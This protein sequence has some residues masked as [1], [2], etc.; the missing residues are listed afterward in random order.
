M[1]YIS[2]VSK[3]EF[4]DKISQQEVKE[5]VFKHM[6]YKFP[7]PEQ[8]MDIFDNAEIAYRNFCKP[9]DYYSL[10]NTFQQKNKE[11]GDITLEYSIKAINECLEKEN[12]RP[13][14]ITDILFISTTGL[15]TP[16][17]DALIVNKLQMNPNINRFPIWGMGCGG[18]VS[19]ISKANA[20]A[21][22]NPDALVLVVAAEMCSLTFLN[23]D[24]SKSNFV[25]LSLFSDGIAAVVVKGDNHIQNQKVKI[26]DSKSTLFYD[27]LDIM[28]WEFLNTGFKVIFSRDIP[29]FITKHARQEIDP[30]LA[31]HNLQMK[32][33]KNYIFH[34][35]GKKVL[36]AYAGVL[37]INGNGLEYSRSVIRDNGNMS[38]P[39]V[40][41]VLEKAMREGFQPGYGLMLAMGPGFCIEMVL[42]QTEEK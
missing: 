29:D 30:F 9:K 13:T 8:A 40:L 18:G 25:A 21:K 38:S 15:S 19:S 42:L 16:S 33:I 6:L 3:I 27:T 36:D 26:I 4:P 5:H 32:D 10:P 34:P 14:D 35:G 2:S 24:F 23:N 12:L 41:Y 31:K 37:N 7:V 20:I 11:Y 1:P 28:G 17:I 22:A 39:T